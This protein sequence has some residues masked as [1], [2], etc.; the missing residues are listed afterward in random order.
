MATFGF[1]ILVQRLFFP[2][3]WMFF[4][5][6]GSRKVPAPFGS[7]SGNTRY[8]VVL[9]ALVATA[10][11]VV[12]VTQSRLGRVLRGMSDSQVA[13][14]TLGLSTNVT[15]IIV[16]C[17][18]AS[19]AA[20]AGVM[21]GMALT[22]VDGTTVAFQPFNSLVLLALLALSPFREPWYAVFAA[23]TG[24]IPAYFG[25]DRTPNVLN[26]FFGL[27]AILV[28]LQ[29][30][31][32]A[33]SPRLREFFGRIGRDRARSVELAPALVTAAGVAGGPGLAV[34]NLTVKFGGLIAV[35]EV[36]LDAPLGRIT[37]LIGPNGAGKTTT[38]DAC[39][40]IN[41]SIGG[42]VRFH[43]V[44]VSS[45][46]APARARM[47][48]GR[49]FQRMELCDTLTVFDNVALGHEC[50]AAGAHIARQVVAPPAERHATFGRRGRRAR[51][52]RHRPP[53]R[54]TGRVALHRG[55]ETRGARPMSGRSLRSPPPRRTV[56]GPGPRTRRRGSAKCCVRLSP[57][58]GA[59]SCSSSTT[60]R[61]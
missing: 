25:G 53:R 27:S 55:A 34:E 50:P 4:T 7:T 57:N 5:F 60:C 38:F 26:A 6:G 61:S 56:V 17:L 44:D 30:G 1:A 42:R 9:A 16:F 33:M 49:T 48:L 52:L 10:V 37:G 36:S 29:G 18:S 23:I 45:R 3:T 8:Y 59:A 32:P 46:G 20:V 40:G 43:G 41:R 39:S 19:I 15:K 24:V 21:Y 54:S 31:H 22:N 11:V 51:S 13:V 47:G 28:A 2:Q 35:D 58:E 12:A 14:S